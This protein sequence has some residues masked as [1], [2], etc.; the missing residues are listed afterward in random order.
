MN[1]KLVIIIGISLVVIALILVVLH[2]E[3]V[4]YNEE[5][6]NFLNG[7]K[8]VIYDIKVEIDEG[9]SIKIPFIN[10]KFDSIQK[11]NDDIKNT[12]IKYDVQEIEYKVGIYEDIMSLGIII[13]ESGEDKYLIYNFDYTNGEV[14]TDNDYIFEKL[15]IDKNK[16]LQKCKEQIGNNIQIS[17]QELLQMPMFID[18]TISVP[19]SYQEDVQKGI[20]YKKGIVIGNIEELKTQE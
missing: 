14:I 20:S 10:F 15:S 19:T 18:G 13:T 11:L 4:K 5:E 9:K 2:I 8:P 7:S 17:E 12:I 3:K 6:Y 16:Y 1:K